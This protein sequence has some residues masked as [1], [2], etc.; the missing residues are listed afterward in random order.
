MQNILSLRFFVPITSDVKIF[1]DIAKDINVGEYC[2]IGSGATICSR[3]S[4]GNY[5]MLSTQVSIFGTDHNFNIVGTP[6]V[7]S[8]RPEQVETVIGSDVWLGHRVIVLGGVT[9]GDGAIVAAGSVVTKDIPDCT[10]Y[11]GVP[12]KFVKDRFSDILES[13]KHIASLKNHL[14]SD[15]PP[16]RRRK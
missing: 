1:S 15:L 14:S 10:I 11:A 6:I 4:I 3:V 13:E 8:G 12:A 9:I 16:S 5:T 7:R 2:Y